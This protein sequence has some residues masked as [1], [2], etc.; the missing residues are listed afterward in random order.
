MP[1]ILE[2]GTIR[3][4]FDY[5]EE[6][7]R[8]YN[9][10]RAIREDMFQ[11]IQSNTID[12]MSA[13]KNLVLQLENQLQDQENLVESLREELQGTNDKLDEAIRNRD[14]FRF[15]GI[16]ILKTLYNTILWTII[17]VLG[18]LT[19]VVFLSIV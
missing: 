7:T 17:A 6:R 8:I 1:E 14:S 4:Q 10:F 12:S 3:E 19:V 9:D 13:E 16:S 2:T 18:F 15:F 5:L 11:K